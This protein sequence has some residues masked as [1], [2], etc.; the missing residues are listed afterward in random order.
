M[1]LNLILAQLFKFVVS[2]VF[3]TSVLFYVGVIVMVPL[4]VLW[5]SI[6][7]AGLIL[8]TVLAVIVGIGVLGYLGLQ[9]SRMQALVD[10]I[11]GVGIDLVAFGFQQKERFEP[12]V[13]AA[14]EQAR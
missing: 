10:A 11:L 13:D 2:L 4:A 14:R 9:V 7:I 5:Y 6:K 3:I 12:I 8:P 1:K